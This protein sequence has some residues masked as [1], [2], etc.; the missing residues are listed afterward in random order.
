VTGAVP[1]VS[2]V[3][4]LRAL[5]RLATA[6]ALHRRGIEKQQVVFDPWALASEHAHQPLQRV[7]QAPAALVIPGLGGDAREQVTQ[8]L[9][10]DSE[11][12]PVRRDSHDRLSDA[13]RDDLRVCDSSPG[14]P[15]PA[16]QEIV[17][18]DIHGSEQQVEVGVHRGPLRSTM[19]QSTADFDPAAYK[20]AR[21]TANPV[22]SII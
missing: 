4:E 14:V 3:R 22:E 2:D 16:R 20:P 18:R 8:M 15:R 9:G 17:S 10:S 11:E 21:S 5:D 12:P 19:L 6:G 13:E 7:S 1:I